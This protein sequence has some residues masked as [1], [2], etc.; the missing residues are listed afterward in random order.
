MPGR[1]E[2][3]ARGT[4]NKVRHLLEVYCE[5][6]APQRKTFG[7]SSPLSLHNENNCSFSSELKM[8]DS[9]LTAGTSLSF[10]LARGVRA[11]KLSIGKC[12]CVCVYALK[13]LEIIA[14]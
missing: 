14:N 2:F 11:K 10:A 12:V 3:A 6:S 4:R 5:I 8:H 9:S 13:K 1:D 7:V